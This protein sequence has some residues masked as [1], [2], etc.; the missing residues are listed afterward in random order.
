MNLLNALTE[1]FRKRQEKKEAEPPVPT[2]RAQRRR[3]HDY[4]PVGLLPE[5][6]EPVMQAVQVPR[7]IMRHRD[8]IMVEPSWHPRRSRKARARIQRIVAA[9]GMM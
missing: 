3:A 9:K 1:R 6:L 4:A 8:V 7:Y 5:G 2:N